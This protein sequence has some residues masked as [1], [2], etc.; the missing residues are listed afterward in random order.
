MVFEPVVRSF[1]NFDAAT[2]AR[3]AIVSSGVNPDLV[4]VQVI[5]DE[6]GPVEGN[7]WIGNGRT[8]GDNVPSGPLAQAEAPY[9]Q[10]FRDTV[11]RGV[12]L[13]LVNVTDTAMRERAN[14]ILDQAGGIDPQ[15]RAASAPESHDPSP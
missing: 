13:V 8:A 4:Q 10:N 9:E 11:N 15:A 2:R 14:N 3:E 6:A 5:Q 12:H 1:D 7:F